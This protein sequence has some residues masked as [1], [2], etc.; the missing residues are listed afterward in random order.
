LPVELDNQRCDPYLFDLYKY[1]CVSNFEIDSDRLWYSVLENTVGGKYQACCSK[2]RLR[3]EDN[4][5][6]SGIEH[7]QSVLPNSN[8]H[9]DL[10]PCLDIVVP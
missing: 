8:I 10:V 9:L 5:I 2:Q 6:T 7:V 4:I 3:F 1:L